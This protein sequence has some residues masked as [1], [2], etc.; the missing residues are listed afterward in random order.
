MV[1]KQR[2]LEPRGTEGAPTEEALGVPLNI[3]EEADTGHR[4]VVYTSKD[5]I[6]IDVRFHGDEP[7]FT[8]LQLAEMFG[9]DVRTVSGHI[10]KFIADGELGESVIR[11]FRITAKDGKIYP[12]NHYA[13]DVAF[14]VGYR[15]TQARAYFFVS[16]LLRSSS[17]SPQ[18][19]L[20]STCG[21][22]KTQTASQTIS[23]NYSNK[24]ATS[25]RRKSG[26]GLAF[27]SLPHSA[28]TTAQ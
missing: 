12:V 1:S 18:K 14:Y 25:V 9:V 24:F 15:V 4:F 19:H 22:W 27:S 8:Q 10:K 7:W 16:G 6:E 26:C 23:K 5:G 3:I 13:L 11:D 21:G 2:S 28:A 17:A 20:L